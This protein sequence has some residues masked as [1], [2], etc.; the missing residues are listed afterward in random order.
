M[1]YNK[2]NKTDYL[3]TLINQLNEEDKEYITHLVESIVK[4][5]SQINQDKCLSQTTNLYTPYKTK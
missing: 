5:N 3:I 4:I 2:S 1:N